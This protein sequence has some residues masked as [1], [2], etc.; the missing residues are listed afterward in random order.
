MAHDAVTARILARIEEGESRV[1]CGDGRV[2][3][4]R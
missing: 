4:E 1:R 2:A 3:D